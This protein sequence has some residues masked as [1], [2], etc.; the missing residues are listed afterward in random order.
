MEPNFIRDDSVGCQYLA[1]GVNDH[2]LSVHVSFFG[3]HF[4]YD[5]Y[6]VLE[7]YSFDSTGVVLAC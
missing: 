2:V 3:P 4:E 1:I 6:F 7:A 5:E